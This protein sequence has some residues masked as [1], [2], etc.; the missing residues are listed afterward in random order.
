MGLC[1]VPPAESLGVDAVILVGLEGVGIK[2]PEQLPTLTS[3]T[4]GKREIKVPLV[5]AGGIGDARGFLG[6]LGMGADGIMMGTAFMATKECPISDAAKER[7]VRASPDDLGGQ[8]LGVVNPQD[9]LGSLAVAVIDHVPT[10]K[11]LVDSIVRGAEELLAS[12]QFLKT[13]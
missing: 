10:V 3:I 5:A 8:V 9:R 11:E 6:A 4:W 7:L 13:R 2:S 1:G 12:W